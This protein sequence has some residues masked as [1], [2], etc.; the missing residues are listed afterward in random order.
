MED[1]TLDHI[2]KIIRGKVEYV[3]LQ[4]D[5]CDQHQPHPCNHDNA[6]TI[7]EGIPTPSYQI[8]FVS[9]AKTFTTLKLK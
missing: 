6:R 3:E 2:V 4:H 9:L 1:N 5:D 7:F 8:H